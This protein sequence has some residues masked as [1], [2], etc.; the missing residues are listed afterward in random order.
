MEFPKVSLTITLGNNRADRRK[1][2]S[3]MKTEQVKVATNVLDEAGNPK[4]DDKG[5]NLKETW[6]I[7]VHV[8][9]EKDIAI[10]VSPEASKF[11]SAEKILADFNRQYSTDAANESRRERTTGGP[12]RVETDKMVA[13]LMSLGLSEEDAKAKVA[14]ASRK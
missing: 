9:D 4:K 1:G 11:V 12:K 2:D 7:T 13:V 5:K 3:A 10:T 6:E 14:E 8:F